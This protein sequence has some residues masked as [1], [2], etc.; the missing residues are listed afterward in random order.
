MGMA[1]AREFVCEDANGQNRLRNK[2]EVR[3]PSFCPALKFWLQK[4]NQCDLP[5]C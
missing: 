1:E 4:S 5:L 2:C 3:R